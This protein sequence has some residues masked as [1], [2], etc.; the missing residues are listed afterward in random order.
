[1][2][3]ANLL[4]RAL[5]PY[6]PDEV[7]LDDSGMAALSRLRSSTRI[8]RRGE[9]FVV[10]GRRHDGIFILTQGFALRYRGLADGRRQ[11]LDI[12][13]PGDTLG[14]SSCF[15][16]TALNTV[17]ALT[18]AA[19]AL[20]ASADLNAAM[21]ALPQ[22]SLALVRSATSE[23]ARLSEHLID[24]GRRNARER[25]A[26]FLL[27]FSVRLAAAGIGTA[28]AF[29]LPITQVQLADVVGLSIPHT[30]RVLRRLREEGLLALT[31]TRVEIKNRRAL[32]A[33]ASFDDAY[34]LPV[35]RASRVICVP[36]SACETGHPRLAASAISRNFSAVA[37]GTTASVSR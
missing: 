18:R 1:M 27:E 22:L 19:V 29:S 24:V 17:T 13:L 5:R 14:C 30:N 9:H 11:V 20:V 35:R 33:L 36:A 25:V 31:G 28:D 32:A 34:L 23:A 8:L 26:H 37:P 7:A 16:G 12:A 4:L 2:Q 3:G 15:L 6:L 10:Q 21:A